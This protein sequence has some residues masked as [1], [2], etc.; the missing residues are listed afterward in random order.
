MGAHLVMAVFVLVPT[1][2][3]IA[4]VPLAWGWGVTWLDLGLALV[5]YVISV[6]G[7]TV[8]YHRYFTHK[9][10][11][12]RRWVQWV[13]GILASSSMQGTLFGWVA[14]HRCHHQHSD[15]PGDP[16]S[17]HVDHGHGQPE[18]VAPLLLVGDPDAGG[19]APDECEDAHQRPEEEGEQHVDKATDKQP[20]RT[21]IAP[22]LLGPQ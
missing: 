19:G 17:P 3:A 20:H 1:A 9:S 7:V 14:T 12:C 21:A 18:H 10:Y 5:F 11:E 6:L 2:S 16:H 4:E 13:I 22:P 8:G 15:R